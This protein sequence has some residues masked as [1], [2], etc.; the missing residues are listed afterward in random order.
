MVS[1]RPADP[2]SSLQTLQQ[3]HLP[4]KSRESGDIILVYGLAD[5][6]MAAAQEKATASAL[7][8]WRH[9]DARQGRCPLMWICMNNY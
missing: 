1:P 8:L 7:V 6:K 4:S 3:Q 9:K 2:G 5:P